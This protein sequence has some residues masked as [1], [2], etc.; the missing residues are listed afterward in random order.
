MSSAA[1]DVDAV[2]VSSRATVIGTDIVPVLLADPALAGSLCGERLHHATDA[3]LATRKT[4]T[5][6]NDGELGAAVAG[7]FGLLVLDGYVLRQVS[8]GSRCAA[9]LLGPGDILQPWVDDHAGATIPFDPSWRIVEQVT[10]A[11]LDR[12]F[13]DRVARWP[14]V[15]E[16]VTQR[17]IERSRALG[18]LLLA[19]RLPHLEARLLALFCQLADR[20]GVMRRDGRLIPIR[21]T[22]QMLGLLIGAQRPSV[23]SALSKLARDG[24]LVRSQDGWLVQG[25]PDEHLARNGRSRDVLDDTPPASVVSAAVT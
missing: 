8:V 9:E 1:A 7:G 25:D 15:A 22:H 2:G 24:V 14:E 16:A 5:R 4:L 19:G 3:A 20:W 18:G 17:M 21:L 23:T 10:C 6:R 13:A 12:G 11:A